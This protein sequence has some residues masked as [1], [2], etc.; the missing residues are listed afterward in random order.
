VDERRIARSHF[1]AAFRGVERRGRDLR[2]SSPGV[3]KSD[4]LLPL[5]SSR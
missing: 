3:K 2:R 4:D 1:E 5:T